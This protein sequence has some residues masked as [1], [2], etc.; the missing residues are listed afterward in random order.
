MSDE[1][2]PCPDCGKEYETTQGLQY[3][4]KT[5]N[6]DCSGIE[7]PTCEADHFWNQLGMEMHHSMSHGESISTT[8]VECANCGKIYEKTRARKQRS[9]KHYCCRKCHAEDKGTNCT[10]N[11]E[12][13]GSEFQV[14]P[15][16]ED[17]RKT[18]SQECQAEYFKEKYAGEGSHW[19]DGG[20]VDLECEICGETFQ[21]Q[22]SSIDRRKT[23]SRDCRK[24]YLSREY[25]GE[26]SHEWKGGSID[27]YGPN[28]EDKRKQALERDNS[29]CQVCGTTD[30]N[31]DSDL[32]VHHITPLRKFV[33]EY[34]GSEAYERAND[35]D[36][37]VTVC[38]PC[39][40]K[41]ERMP[42]FPAAD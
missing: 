1:Q 42:V 34:S 5:D 10:K 37:L 38:R 36:N 3:H 23:C 7:C 25:S 22:K 19:W 13:C 40:R 33:N 27:Y 14:R 24:E 6:N 11:C 30:H 20:R 31:M 15:A 29:Q 28:W 26:N 18:C 16:N 12:V 35:L 21:A 17:R 9:N 32:E 4:L 39:H 8:E 41:W 2:H